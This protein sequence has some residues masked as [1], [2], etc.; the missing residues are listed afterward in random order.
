VTYRTEVVLTDDIHRPWVGRLWAKS[1]ID[2]LLEETALTGASSEVRNEVT[3]L[4]L[5]YNFATPYTSF[6]A[7]PESEVDA[8]SAQALASARERKQEVM[9]R[10]SGSVQ[11]SE[12]ALGTARAEVP[13]A[14]P[15]APDSV[16]VPQSSRAQPIPQDDNEAGGA[17]NLKNPTMVT[18]D[19]A[20]VPM[21]NLMR[22]E[23]VEKKGGCASCSLGGHGGGE[24][25]GLGLLGLMAALAGTRRLRRRPPQ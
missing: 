11:L 24:V 4:A 5:A 16:V 23:R 18:D 22:Q 13:S 9:R 20:S 12:S 15:P 17:D 21:K 1:R 7:I 8:V 19:S 3:E 10:K 14:S 2:D 25:A 6:L